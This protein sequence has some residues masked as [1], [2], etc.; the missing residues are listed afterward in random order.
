MQSFQLPGQTL[1]MTQTQTLS[2]LRLGVEQLLDALAHRLPSKQEPLLIKPCLGLD[3]PAL[4]GGSSDFRLLVALIEA[5]RVRG[6]QSLAL[7]ESALPGYHRAGVKPWRR[8]RLDRLLSRYGIKLLDVG[9]MASTPVKIPGGTVR[10]LREALDWPMLL[11]SNVRT[12]P[13]LGLGMGVWN[14]KGLVHPEDRARLVLGGE[15]SMLALVQQLQPRLCLLDLGVVMEGE[16]PL[17]GTPRRLDRLLGGEQ[18]LG[19]D[20][21]ATRLLG[22]TPE[23]VPT[24]WTALQE[25]VLLPEDQ[26]W[27]EER[28]SSV[29]EL[30][31][32][33]VQGPAYEVTDVVHT[34]L[35]GM[36]RRRSE[37]RGW[38]RMAEWLSVRHVVKAEAD[39]PV[40][41]LR[42][43]A[44]CGECR[45]CEDFCPVGL[46]REELGKPVK[47]E[48]CVECLYC[49]QVCDRG[50]LK[51]EGERGPLLR[52]IEAHKTS[53]ERL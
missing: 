34:W 13:D 6:F 25:H 22:Y 7:A 46:R 9:L 44:L 2:A 36:L 42:D 39:P 33:R 24:L 12:H 1:Y 20:L 29:A 10:V 18:A 47:A 52:I 15:P 45:R 31:R 48:A 17:E 4:L 16:G 50:A 5:L 27:L 53:T 30:K 8:L 40:R 32:P 41:L 35:K 37:A 51:V 21:L 14:L 43:G 26:V 3:R 23:E 19:L 28:V 11:V 38:Q 49:Y